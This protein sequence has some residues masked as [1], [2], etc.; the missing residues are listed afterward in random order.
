ML[1]QNTFENH[2][3]H[4]LIT[5]TSNIAIFAQLYSKNAIQ[6][7]RNSKLFDVNHR[8]STSTGREMG[9]R[10]MRR[11]RGWGEDGKERKRKRMG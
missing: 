3:S 4:F 2:R 1:Y 5:R 7:C 6:R 9:G 8:T 11:G 10:R